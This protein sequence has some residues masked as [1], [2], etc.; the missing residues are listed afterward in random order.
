MVH[1]REL[2]SSIARGQYGLLPAQMDDIRQATERHISGLAPTDPARH[3]IASRILETMEWVRL[4]VLAQRQ[5]Y[6][7]QLDRLPNV[8]LYLDRHITQETSFSVDL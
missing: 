3:Q 7:D 1:E 2:R 8:G 5:G 4:M 6:L